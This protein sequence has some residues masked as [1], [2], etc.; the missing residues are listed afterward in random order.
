VLMHLTCHLPRE[1]LERVLRNARKAGI[2]NILAL[3]GDPPIGSDQWVPADG[4]F[5][6]AH[7]L[8]TLIRKTHGDFFS[9]AVAGYPEAHTESWN[10]QAGEAAGGDAAPKS[11]VAGGP[12]SGQELWLP[13]SDQARRTDLTR[14]AH[15]VGCGADFMVTQFFYDVGGFLQFVSEC[16]DQGMDIPILPGYMPIQTYRGF[17]KFTQW[18]KTHVPAAVTAD[19]LAIRDDD[20][21][22]KK[23]GAQLAARTC[24][25]LLSCGSPCLHFYTMN[26]S[27]TVEVVLRELGLHPAD[28]AGAGT[29]SAGVPRRVAVEGIGAVG[30]PPAAGSGTGTSVRGGVFA[31]STG[32]AADVPESKDST[33]AAAGE[34]EEEET[35]LA[36]WAGRAPV[37]AGEAVR[38][39]FWSNRVTSYLA[40]TSEWDWDG[41]PNGRWGDSKSPAFGDV[42]EYYLAFKRPKVDR[43]ALW[44]IPQSENDVARVFTGFLRGDVSSLPWCDTSPAAE[45]GAIA[46]QLLW[47]NAHGVLTINSQ[48]AVNGCPSEDPT[49]GWGPTGGYCF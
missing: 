24:R 32:A 6:N 7:E 46:P 31:T 38:P 43:K 12:P 41:F 3:R 1:Q 42:G 23:Y 44:G 4:G 10:D 48:P 25:V 5:K 15:K 18:C 21:A 34:H 9:I 11:Q 16:R 37:R 49:F 33:G 13:P 17:A 40:R 28:R 45:T 36:P 26:L 19:L 30:A 47:L 2:R 27:Q 35:I 20:A 8:V 22:V 29:T 39:I 14:L